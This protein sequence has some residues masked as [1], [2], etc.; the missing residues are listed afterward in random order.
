MITSP[1]FSGVLCLLG[2]SPRAESECETPL[3]VVVP[4]TEP[5]MAGFLEMFDWLEK[6]RDSVL[7]SG[8][9]PSDLDSCGKRQ[10]CGS[11]L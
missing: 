9:E 10:G 7:G 11:P 8:T 2:S 4:S 5:Y 6:G 3:F 1:P